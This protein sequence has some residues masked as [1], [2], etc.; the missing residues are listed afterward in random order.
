MTERKMT[1]ATLEKYFRLLYREWRCDVTVST[2]LGF[3]KRYTCL[4]LGWPK[5]D[6]SIEKNFVEALTIVPDLEIN[7]LLHIFIGINKD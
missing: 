1:I 2:R 5:L 3:E 7:N 4:S 6:E